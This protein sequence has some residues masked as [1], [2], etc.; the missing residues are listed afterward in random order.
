M[1]KLI[2]KINALLFIIMAV[3]AKAENFDETIQ[4]TFDDWLKVCNVK[5]Q[6]CVGV[7]FAQNVSG[8]KVGRFVLDIFP[9]KKTKIKAVGTLLIPYETA[10]PHLLSGVILKLDQQKPIKEQFLFCDKSGCSVRYNFTAAGLDQI[11]SGSNILI[12]FKD[13][14]EINTIKTMDISLNGIKPFLV[15]ME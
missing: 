1:F 3:S 14:R 8:K 4:A 5:D 15:S 13:I 6:N 7:T 10:I 12:K 2:I 11:Q 9:Q